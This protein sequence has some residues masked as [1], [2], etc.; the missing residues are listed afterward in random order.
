MAKK[1]APTR[2]MSDDHKAALAEGR[3][4]G[5]AIR[6]YLEGLELT[7]PKRGRKRTPDTI[8]ARLQTLEET[9]PT[10][11]PLKRVALIQ[12]RNDLEAELSNSGP[13]VDIEA[14]EAGFVAAAKGY[15]ERKGITYAAWRE[16][17]VPAAVLKS[18]GISRAG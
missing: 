11:D 1:P 13:E 7:R 12:E 6:N 5:R 15:S 8:A 10:V 3:E 2:S 14:L 17:G 16:I 9:I 18:A 4:Q